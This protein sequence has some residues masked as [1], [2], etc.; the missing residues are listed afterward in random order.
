M[1]EQVHTSALPARLV[2]ASVLPAHSVTSV[3]S[4]GSGNGMSQEWPWV[5]NVLVVG[6]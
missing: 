5:C 3:A 4:G 1:G 6:M 2:H